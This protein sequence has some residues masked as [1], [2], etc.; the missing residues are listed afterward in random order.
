MRAAAALRDGALRSVHSTANANSL[1]TASRRSA[2][3]VAAASQLVPVAHAAE[4]RPG[5]RGNLL[6]QLVSAGVEADL[7]G[8]QLV[9]AIITVK[10]QSFGR[11]FLLMQVC[12]RATRHAPLIWRPGHVK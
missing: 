6:R 1:A 4:I 7:F 5:A 9:A 3:L 8:Q 2:V 11:A 12:A 10:W